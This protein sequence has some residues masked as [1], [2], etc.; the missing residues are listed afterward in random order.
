MLNIPNITLYLHIGTHKTGSTA[1][2]HYLH[3]NKDSLKKNRVHHLHNTGAFKP[4]MLLDSFDRK[5]I[6]KARADL[7]SS[8]KKSGANHGDSIVIS[9]EGFSGNPLLGYSNSSA[10]ADLVQKITDGLNAH[11]IIYL[12][13]QDAFI[14]SLYTQSIHEGG[15]LEFSDFLNRLPKNSFNWL[16]FIK[17]YKNA[18]APE[19]LH[20][21]S[22]DSCTSKGPEGLLVDFM[23]CLGLCYFE[24]SQNRPPTPNRGYSR[25][26]LEIARIC[27]VVFT[28]PE[29]TMLREVL[30]RSSAKR[31]F[32]DYSLMSPD[33]RARCAQ[34]FSKTN[35][36]LSAIYFPNNPSCLSISLAPDQESRQE[37]TMNSIAPDIIRII[38]DQEKNNPKSI[39]VG[40]LVRLEKWIQRTLKR[41]PR[42]YNKISRL[43]KSQGRH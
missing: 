21:R 40:V 9:W 27:N 6:S 23:S 12:R 17:P 33:D 24:A 18:L 3:Q 35:K 30:Q 38:L 15:S 14:Q 39:L 32:K 5:V 43:V 42:T 31:L 22:Y 1:I 34:Y 19:K 26:A 7:L 29:K 10:I 11:I 16:D 13:R 20:I 37:T 4:L 41:F 28:N 36:Q 2:Q 8:I 25:S